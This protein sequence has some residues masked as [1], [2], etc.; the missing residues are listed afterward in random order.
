MAKLWEQD[1][2]VQALIGS[3]PF[4][5]LWLTMSHLRL[6]DIINAAVAAERKAPFRQESPGEWI[7]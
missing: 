5:G 3:V 7:P 4:D 1:A 2:S 6:W